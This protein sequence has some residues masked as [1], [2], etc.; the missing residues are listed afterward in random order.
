[1][2]NAI[3]GNN[4]KLSNIIISVEVII[5]AAS[6]FVDVPEEAINVMKKK[7]HSE[8]YQTRHKVWNDTLQR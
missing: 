5:A 8:E 2:R 7:R 4:L 6:R 1:M 3:L